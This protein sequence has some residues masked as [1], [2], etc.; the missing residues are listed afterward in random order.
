MPVVKEKLAAND[1]VAFPSSPSSETFCCEHCKTCKPWK[2]WI[3][4]WVTY[5]TVLSILLIIASFSLGFLLDKVSF[6]QNTTAFAADTPQNIP[7]SPNGL[8][9]KTEVGIGHLPILGKKSAKITIVEFADFQCPF[10]K[11]WYEEVG[12]NIMKEYVDSGKV[13]FAF[14]HYAFLDKANFDKTSQDTESTWSAEAS[15]CANE[16]GKFWEFHN[17]LFSHQGQEN[18]GNFNKDKLK[19]FAKALNLNTDKFNSCLDSNRYKEK[20]LQ[21]FLDGQKA[22][23]SGTPT[24]FIDGKPLVGYTPY[25]AFKTLLDAELKAAH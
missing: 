11:K 25:T 18:A 3:F 1:S 14:R 17:Y 24:V 5:P 13:Q 10:C 12:K 6:L 7:P 4:R 20:V 16:Q 9:P 19:E 21:D 22:G 23:V 8:G 15:E 2:Q